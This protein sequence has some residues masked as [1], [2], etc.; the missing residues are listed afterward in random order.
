MSIRLVLPVAAS[1]IELSAD[2]KRGF[3]IDRVNASTGGSLR[4]VPRAEASNI[5]DMR[6]NWVKEPLI[7]TNWCFR[8]MPG[9][10]CVPPTLNWTQETLLSR[11]SAMDVSS[12]VEDYVKFMSSER[13]S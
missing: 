5:R 8:D 4:V 10:P 11:C 7:V 12:G 13:R 3:P 2:L 9:V 6:P 1:L